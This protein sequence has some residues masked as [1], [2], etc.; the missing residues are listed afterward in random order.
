M[1]EHA[2]LAHY[3]P[4]SYAEAVAAVVREE[5]YAAMLFAGTSQGKDL[6]PRVAALLD[7]PLATEATALAI[8]G[9][10]LV[11]VRPVYAGKAFARVRSE[12]TPFLVSLRPNV[13]QPVDRAAAG[14]VERFTPRVSAPRTRVVEFRAAAG[15][16]VDVGEATVVVSGAAG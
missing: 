5:D 1:G 10:T 12:A 3:V 13:F 11:V 16:S 8:E 7:V 14:T 9:G 6:A 2:A 4:E 15:G